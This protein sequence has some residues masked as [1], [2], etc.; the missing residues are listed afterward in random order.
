MLIFSLFLAIFFIRCQAYENKEASEHGS[1]SLKDIGKE[2]S[3]FNLMSGY[4][5]NKDQQKRQVKKSSVKSKS[6]KKV[7]SK[8]SKTASS[9]YI[10]M[11]YKLYNDINAL[12]VKHSVEKLK[13]NV[14]L[15]KELQKY[16]EGLVKVVQTYKYRLLQPEDLYYIVKQGEKYDPIG[17]WSKDLELLSDKPISKYSYYYDLPFTKLIWKSST[18][19]GCGISGADNS[20]SRY[21]I[22]VYCRISPK[23]NI[24]EKFSENVFLKQG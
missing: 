19:I 17:F 9:Q 11:K 15:S 2:S 23:G 1:L 10:K 18:H 14:T 7:T 12:R 3:K 16:V 6:S 8:K 24:A 22:I 13:V 5:E 4:N 20:R 21:R